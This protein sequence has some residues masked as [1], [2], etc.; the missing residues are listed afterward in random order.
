[1]IIS[2]LRYDVLRQL[3]F[4]MDPLVTVGS[5]FTTFAAQIGF[6]STYIR[7]V[8]YFC[9]AYI[10]FVMY[11]CSTYIRFVMYF[12]STYIRFVM[13]FCSAYIRFVMYF[14]FTYIR[15]VGGVSSL[16]PLYSFD[17]YALRLTD[18]SALTK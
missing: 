3:C 17:Y 2:T 1:M 16:S 14:C 6:C 12:C 4:M 18:T 15:F 5:D 13:Y 9:S 11:F 8:M 7:F 10:R